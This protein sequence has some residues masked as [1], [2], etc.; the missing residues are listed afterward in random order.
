MGKK[1]TEESKRKMKAA[2]KVR[3]VSEATREA[4]KK[5][6]TGRKRAPF[7]EET[8]IKMKFAAKEREAQKRANKVG[9]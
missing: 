7:S 3:G 4:N 1:H 9:P 5:A 8:I 2:A 6:L